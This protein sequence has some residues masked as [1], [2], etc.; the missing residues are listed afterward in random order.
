VLSL[1][2]VVTAVTSAITGAVVP[3]VD[4]SSVVDALSVVVVLSA[5][6][7]LLLLVL[8]DELSSLLQEIIMKLNNEIR[9]Y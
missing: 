1:V 9:T 7:A 5:V 3:V 2:G 6:V 8:I 4:E